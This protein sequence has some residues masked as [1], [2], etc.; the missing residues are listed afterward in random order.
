[1]YRH[2]I[3]YL[4]CQLERLCLLRGLRVLQYGLQPGQS[5]SAKGNSR[6]DGDVEFALALGHQL[7]EPFYDPRRL[8]QSAI[9]RKQAKK[10]L[11]DVRQGLLL[12]TTTRT[13]GSTRVKG[14]ETRVSV[15]EGK[16]GIR[17]EGFQFWGFLDGLGDGVE[18]GVDL[19]QDLWRFGERGRIGG[20]GVF[21]SNSRC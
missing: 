18:L 12:R 10:V 13:F 17:D 16:G 19:R 14:G 11:R 2:I 8:R 20:V 9:L 7:I 15:S 6:G 1:M 21:E 5:V 3:P 4:I